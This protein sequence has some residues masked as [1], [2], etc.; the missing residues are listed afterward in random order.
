MNFRSRRTDATRSRSAGTL[1]ASLGPDRGPVIVPVDVDRLV[2]DWA[3]AEAAAR[4]SELHVVHAFR[5]AQQVDA[6]GYPVVDLRARIEAEAFVAATIR[7]VRRT[8]P[9]LRIRACVY[10]GRQTTA[11]INEARNTVD[12]LVVLNHAPGRIPARRLLRRTSASLAVVC[13]SPPGFVARAT[14]QVV[15]GVDATGG[16]AS[17]LGFAFRAARRRGIG[18]T[19]IH[20]LSSPDVE[21]IEDTVRIWQTAYPEVPVRWSI[22]TGTVD[23]LLLAESTG[24]ALTVLGPDRHHWLHRTLKGSP[25][26]TILRLNRGPLV[27]VHPPAL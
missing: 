23:S 17:V 20:A 1:R 7:R 27:I 13:L 12:A 26:N 11:L 10:A 5:W 22:D 14:G 15:V 8:M 2:L 3:A 21:E 9:S 16:P 6:G 4:G 19:V 25:T 24:A 18:L